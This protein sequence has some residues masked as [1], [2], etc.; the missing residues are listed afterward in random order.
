MWEWICH[1]FI[2]NGQEEG[3]IIIVMKLRTVFHK[4]THSL[5]GEKWLEFN[6]TEMQLIR[7]VQPHLVSS[8]AIDSRVLL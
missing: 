7:C 8:V 5:L 3:F 2:Q 6:R 4:G 1:R